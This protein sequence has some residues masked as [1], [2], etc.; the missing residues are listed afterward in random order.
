MEGKGCPTL[1][2]QTEE[3]IEWVRW[4]P[5]SEWSAELPGSYSTI[6][7]VAAAARL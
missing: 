2:P 3:G 1:S 5:E 4:V 7:E 6:Q